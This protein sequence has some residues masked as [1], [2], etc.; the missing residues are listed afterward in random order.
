MFVLQTIADWGMRNADFKNGET[1]ECDNYYLS[2][3]WVKGREY[4]IVGKG[5]MVIVS[6]SHFTSLSLFVIYCIRFFTDGIYVVIQ[7]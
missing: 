3:Q 2:K 6:L 4:K 5:R 1:K 7:F